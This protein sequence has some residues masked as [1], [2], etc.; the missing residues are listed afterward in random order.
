MR[1]FKKLVGESVYLSPINPDDAELYTKWV[2]DAEMT[3]FLMMHSKV[4]GLASEREA[5]ERLADGGYNLAIV[6]AQDDAPIGGI[7]LNGID[8]VYRKGM[9][10]I[11]IGET[12]NCSKGYGAEAIRLLLG[13][14]FDTLGLHNINLQLHSDNA[15]ALACY[16]KVGFREYGRRHECVF[17]HGRYFDEIDMEILE[18]DFRASQRK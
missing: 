7:T 11:Y 1:Y 3:Q 13:F 15:R 16:T 12:E 5:L 6:R 8:C 9:L 14:A 10:G 17:K 18:D 4:Y 2:N